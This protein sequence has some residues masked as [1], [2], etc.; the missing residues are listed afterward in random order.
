MIHGSSA[1]REHRLSY[2]CLMEVSIHI[3]EN[4]RR[5]ARHKTHNQLTFFHT[6]SFFLQQM[7]VIGFKVWPD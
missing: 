3:D 5:E 4:H 7:T 2:E 1:A 6:R